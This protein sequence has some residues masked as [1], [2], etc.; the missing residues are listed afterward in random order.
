MKNI[1]STICLLCLC[2]QGLLANNGSPYSRFGIGELTL[3]SSVRSLSLGSTGTALTSEGYIDLNNPATL[4]T[5]T[6]TLFNG[7]YQY[8]GYES[9]DNS[10]SSYLN[11]GG[12]LGGALAFPV[13]KP[14]GIVFAF[15]LAPV[16]RANYY[17]KVSDPYGNTTINQTFNGSGGLTALQFSLSYSPLTDLS[18]GMTMDYMFGTIKSEQTLSYADATYYASDLLSTATH[19]GLAFHFGALQQGLD[20]ILGLST[21]KHV[22]LGVTLFTGGSL[23]TTQDE[24]R[25]LSSKDTTITTPDG[26]TKLPL[27]F[28]AGLS[29]LKNNVVY[30]GDVNVQQWSDFKALGVHPAEIQNSMRAGVGIEWLPGKEFIES[31]WHQVAYRIGGYARQTYVKVDGTSINEYFATA[32]LGLPLGNEARLNIGLEYGI[33]GTL[34]SALVKSN[35]IRLTHSIS[36]GDLWFQPSEIE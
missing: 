2:A 27:G 33:S 21:T 1:F 7:S 16:S 13:Y 28:S 5:I 4:G 32:G 34:S 30:T 23:A 35:L 3:T 29:Y 22:T 15:G 17:F 6:R 8:R 12:Y 18:L 26:T 36:A 24:L 31:Y 25:H 14:Y 19:N 10:T 9:R 20:K 11:A